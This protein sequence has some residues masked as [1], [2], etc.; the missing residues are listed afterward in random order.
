[1]TQTLPTRTALKAQ[2]KALR[3]T[4][5]SAGHPM[6]HSM[7]LE[8]LAHSHGFRDWNALSAAAPATQPKS[9]DHLHIGAEVHGRYLGHPFTGRVLGL[10]QRSGGQHTI[11]TVQFD[12]AIDVVASD[13]FSSLRRRV[14]ATL[15]KSGVSPQ[16]T[17]DGTPHMVLQSW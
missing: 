11:V 17:S 6:T 14:K 12:K 13:K 1:M 10:Q 2:A 16:H 5:T 8:T 7:A 3:A 4:S 9:I 15:D